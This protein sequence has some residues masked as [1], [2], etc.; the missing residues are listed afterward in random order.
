MLSP[1]LPNDSCR[2]QILEKLDGHIINI[3][4]GNSNISDNVI[5]VDM[6]DYENVSIVAD[7]QELPFKDETIDGIFSIAVLEH[8]KEP[9]QVLNEC[10]RVLKNGGTIFSVIPFMQP[11]HASPHDYQ[12]YSKPGIEFL[13]KQFELIK[14]GTYGGPVSG[15]LWIFQEFIALLLSF[16]IKPLR[17]FIYLVV[18]VLTWPIKLLD[19]YFRQLGTSENIASTFFYYGRKNVNNHSRNPDS[20]P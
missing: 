19:Y 12:R 14:S 1:V 16:G 20:S 4:S 18:M 17:D 3:G 5:N 9:G 11:F 15:F 13:H 10:Y 6:F 8:I 7:I 2:K